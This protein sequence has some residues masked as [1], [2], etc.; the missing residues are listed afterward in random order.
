MKLKR[1]PEDF[2][3]EE[4]TSLAPQ[5]SGRYTLYRL[6][7]RGIGTI[8]A[9]EAIC[10]RWNLSGRRVSYGGLKDRHAVTVQYLTIL[11]GPDRAIR[12]PSFDLEPLGRAARPYGP[13]QFHA[14]RFRIVLRNLDR[15]RAADALAAARELPAAGLPNYFDDQ[16]FG[17]VGFSGEF[18]AAAW[19]KA[20]HE[21]A[22]FLALAE[23]NPF[24]RSGVK[25]QKEILRECWGRWAEAK[26]RLERSSTRSIV[27]YLT[28]HPTD[29]RG[30]FARLK[31]E[32]RTLYFS[33]FQSHLWNVW[34]SRWIESL[35]APGERVMVDLK[36]AVLA[37]PRSLNDSARAALESAGLPLPSA[38]TP[39]PEGPLGLLIDEALVPF[40]L[41]WS[42][43][44]VRHLKDVF[45]SKGRRAALVFPRDL[46][47]ELLDDSL[48]PG[49]QALR[50]GFELDKGSYATI[51]VK[52]ITELP[53]A[54]R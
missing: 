33:A 35:T 27:T 22:L 37:F 36:T 5:P 54:G 48:H 17:S 51:L 42:D 44:R 23:P 31:R 9:V 49:M 10:R 8:E 25:A 13:D 30:A 46:K 3:V 47:A 16:R 12:E 20:D 26:A 50:L 2:Q 28:D 19:L 21:R 1:T 29:Y 39:P 6:N 24:D 7:K 40:G 32:L 11:D 45:F 34:L 38:R 52:R 15:R 53:G 4:L 41:S 43:L 14:N 18:I